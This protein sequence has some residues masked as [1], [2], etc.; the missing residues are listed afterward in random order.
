[1]T[2]RQIKVIR[3]KI[4]QIKKALAADKKQWGGQYHDGRGLR[5]LPP[6]YF[7]KLAD[8]S[9]A[10]RYFNWFNKN[11]P[12]D[13][14]YP[15]FLFEW[16]ITLFYCGKLKEAEK[17]AFN[18]FLQN[19]YYFDSYFDYSIVLHDKVHGSNWQSPE[20]TDGFIYSHTQ[21]QLTE[22]SNWLRQVIQSEKFQKAMNAYLEIEKQLN[23]VPV[24]PQRSEL[25]RQLGDLRNYL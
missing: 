18:T 8:Y 20:I 24:G 7:L 25:V 22:F 15:D 3:T 4:D 5:Y 16:T 19:A 23:V 11:F 17:M 9:G 14:G 12:D 1:M 21:T 13:I 2:E 6:Q 10:L